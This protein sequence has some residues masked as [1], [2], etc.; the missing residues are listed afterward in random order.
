MLNLLKLIHQNLILER[1]IMANKLSLRDEIKVQNKKLKDMTFAQKKEYIWEYYRIHI[2]GTLIAIVT[3]I[4][5]IIMFMRNDY[6]AVFTTVV[7]DGNM[8]GFNDNTDKL[9]VGFTQYLGIDGKSKRVIFSN[10]YSLIQRTGDEDAYYS[11]Q[12]IVAM[13]TTKSIDGYLC[14]YDYA[15]FYSSDDE[16]FLTDLREL[17]TANELSKLSDYLVYYTATD[18]TKFPIAVDLTSTRVKTETDLTMT[19]P[20]YGV[21]ST[22]T[23]TDNAVKFIKYA[24][25]L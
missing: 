9:T 22:S 25:G 2:I 17:F 16:L 5:L 14:E 13:A 15:T 11:T 24:F 7:V 19:R 8:T 10:N 6:K 20:C 12:K 4:C 1:D 21:V 3:V 23:H 18:G